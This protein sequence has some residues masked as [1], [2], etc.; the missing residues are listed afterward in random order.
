MLCTGTCSNSTHGSHPLRTLPSSP[1]TLWPIHSEICP[2]VPEVFRLFYF[3]H[4]PS[5]VPSRTRKTMKKKAYFIRLLDGIGAAADG[6]AGAL[7]SAELKAVAKSPV[8]GLEVP[9]AAGAG[10]LSPLCFLGPVVF[11]HLLLAGRRRRG[12]A[13]GRTF[14]GLSGGVATAGACVLLD[15]ERAATTTAAHGVRFV[16]WGR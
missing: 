7:W 2:T 15:V 1:T 12:R 4:A 8:D 11:F 3:L 14:P 13:K 10:G 5:H 16:L 9:H 6:P